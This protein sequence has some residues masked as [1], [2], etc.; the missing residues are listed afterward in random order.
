MS[1]RVA[2]TQLVCETLRAPRT[3][4]R[5]AL[6]WL[7]GMVFPEKAS[8]CVWPI[9]TFLLACYAIA[10]IGRMLSSGLLHFWSELL[11]VAF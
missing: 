3:L 1:N 4:P 11:R 2:S 5:L 6:V 8:V 7:L 9:P 10:A